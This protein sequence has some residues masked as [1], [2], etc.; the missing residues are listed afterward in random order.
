MALLEWNSPLLAHLNL[1]A[2]DEDRAEALI[3]AASTAIENYLHRNLEHDERDRVFV[4]RTGDVFLNAYPVDY[5]ARICTDTLDVLTIR[6]TGEVASFG[7]G[8]DALKL[9]RIS[10]G[11]RVNTS[12]AFA[13]YPT[14]SALA[15][16]MPTGF[17][18][19]VADGY[20]SYP[21][22]ELVEGQSGSCKYGAKLAMWSDNQGTYEVDAQRG[23]IHFVGSSWRQ[24][25]LADAAFLPDQVRVVWSGGYTEIPMDLQEVCAELVANKW[26]DRQG[27][28]VSESLGEY[29]YTISTSDVAQL[30]ITTRGKLTT[31]RNRGV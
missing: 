13:T 20:S 12:L 5:I 18:A 21:T 30:P 7:V 17:T 19:T 6:A 16:A 8:A 25:W 4:N 24:A 11:V 3:Q 29:S 2:D 28:V 1:T 14:L 31:Y 23:I 27:V 22:S 15:A 10:N 26:K 9:V